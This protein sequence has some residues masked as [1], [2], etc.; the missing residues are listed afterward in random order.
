MTMS[1]EELFF[2]FTVLVLRERLFVCVCV[3][4][5]FGFEGGCDIWQY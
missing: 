2:R 4:Y 1:G 5:S 3:S